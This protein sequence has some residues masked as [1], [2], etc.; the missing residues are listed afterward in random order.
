MFMILNF[1]FAIKW[2]IKENPLTSMRENPCNAWWRLVLITTASS[3]RAPSTIL[4]WCNKMQ[5]AGPFPVSVSARRRLYFWKRVW[6]IPCYLFQLLSHVLL[7]ATPWSV[8]C[9]ALLSMAFS[10]QKYWSGLPFPPLGDLPDSRIK[11]MSPALAGRFFTAQ[12]P[13]KV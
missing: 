9:Q 5:K 3:R 10:R 1:P 6:E 4:W 12:P 2:S 8:A 11:P 7:F 13:G